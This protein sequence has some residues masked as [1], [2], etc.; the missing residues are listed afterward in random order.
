MNNVL[1]FCQNCYFCLDLNV[2]TVN[3]TVTTNWT[4]AHNSLITNEDIYL[5]GLNL[6]FYIHK[7]KELSFHSHFIGSIQNLLQSI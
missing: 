2:H 1:F 5:V 6:L 3:L 4:L 7:A